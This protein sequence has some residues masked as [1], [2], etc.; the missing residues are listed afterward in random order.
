LFYVL[1]RKLSQKA[2]PA[3]EPKLNNTEIHQYA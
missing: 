1:T 2:L 3:T